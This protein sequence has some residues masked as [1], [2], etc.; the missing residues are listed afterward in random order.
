M[1][2][3]RGTP[4]TTSKQIGLR[5]PADLNRQLEDL[6]QKENNGLSAVCRR[7]LSRGLR[8]EQQTH[9]NGEAA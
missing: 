5:L 4:E 6:A 1:S 3:P 9:P 2:K 7:L 8:E